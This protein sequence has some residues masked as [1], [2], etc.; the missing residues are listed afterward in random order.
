MSEA[1]SSGNFESDFIT[2]P[3]RWFG[4]VVSKESW[5]GNISS[6][7]TTNVGDN[8]GWGY[9]Y[10]VRIFSWY[11]GDTNTVPDDQLPMASVVLPTTAG[12]GMGG[13]GMTPSIEPGSLVTGFFMDGMG[14]QEPWI[15]GILGN[16]N[17]NIPKKQ[18]GKSPTDKKAL[19]TPPNVDQLSADS[20]KR[21]LNPARTPTSAEF[22]A[23]SQARQLAKAAGLS[24]A[25][26]ERQVLIATVKAKDAAISQPSKPQ[27]LGYSALNDTFKDGTNPSKVPDFCRVG[28]APLSTFDAIQLKVESTAK[29]LK[30]SIKKVPLLDVSK[31][32][33]SPIKGIQQTMKNF[34][35]TVQ[36]LKRE[37]NQATST[38]G[39]PTF[40]EKIQKVLGDASKEIAK[41]TKNILGGVKSFIFDKLDVNIKK[42]TP[43]LF[44]SE[45]P[46]LYD[47][48]NQGLDKISCLFKNII[49]GLQ[50][51]IGGLLGGILDKFVTAPSCAAQNL[52]SKILNPILAILTGGL[53]SILGPINALFSS[54]TGITSLATNLLGTATSSLGG[55]VGSISGIAGSVSGVFGQLS[56]VVGSLG[57]IGGQIEGL[58]EQI[59][60]ALG[61]LGG[62]SLDG[63]GS[64]LLSALD[65]IPGILKF[66]SCDE[67]QKKPSYNT[68]TQ[69]GPAIPGAP[70]ADLFGNISKVIGSVTAIQGQIGGLVGQV[71]GIVDQ[72]QSL[73]SS[74]ES[75][76]N[77]LLN[78]VSGIV[79]QF[80]GIV[81]QFA[82][83]ADGVSG[84]SGNCNKG[85][86]ACGPPTVTIFGGGGT[87]AAANAVI[88]PESSSVIAFNIINPGSGY[89]TPPTVVLE[90][91]CG[92]GNGSCLDAVIEDG[93]LTNIVICAPGNGYLPAPDG[94]LG[95]DGATWKAA[96]E[97]Y[98]E[99]PDGDTFVVQPGRPINVDAGCTYYAPGQPPVVL[100][101]AQTITLGLQAVQPP[102]VETT[103]VLL[104]LDSIE[105]ADGGFG[106][107]QGDQI[108]ITPDN[109][110][111]AEPVINDRGQIERINIVSGGCG[112]TDL[113]EIRTNS[114]TGF[115][116]EFLP[117]LKVT[118]VADVTAIP[119]GIQ[120]VQVVD[121]VGKIPPKQDFFTVTR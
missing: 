109:G 107:E 55:L 26:V 111:V 65:F 106:Y 108:I 34:L 38:Q 57:A 74:G 28:D 81:G 39:D 87:G 112:F 12:S 60:S 44:P 104:C 68:I 10:K 94:S 9:R 70:G 5:T 13:S 58:G 32:G 114:E 116:A 21:L 1:L 120:V 90:D 7:K 27:F 82:D 105:V 48:V 72:I 14:G 73:I 84:S 113:P 61:K 86:V 62:L 49:G 45:M 96:D 103:P 4:R 88:S 118:P 40:L 46:K 19:P 97:G 33:N 75:V 67:P 77:Y 8:K 91:P 20:L 119:A 102:A 29:S 25:E 115:N 85:P 100:E 98:V 37:Y 50:G 18:G 79:G 110:V 99:C 15:D 17:N 16:S 117:V 89:T 22:A 51:L 36:E 76:P 53:S 23:A 6:S 24:S 78:Q 3:P 41:F 47:L 52:M 101:Q 80:S 71:T 69:D 31:D 66:F 83:L 64:D 42:I 35:N 93:K 63:L 59:G 95:G 56:G 30:D 121:C 54:V 92:R 43:Y 2:H 11:T